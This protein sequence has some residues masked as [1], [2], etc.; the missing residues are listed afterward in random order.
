MPVKPRDPWLDNAKMLL[1]TAVV[2]GHALVLIPPSDLSGRVYDAIYYVHIPAFV[3]ITGY[4]SRSFE[5]TRRH[6]RSL[7]TTL[8]V[9]YLVF[10]GLFALFRQEA[11]GEEPLERLWLDPHWP[12]WYLAVLM[13]WR[14]ATPLLKRHWVAIPIS[15][16]ISVL[17]PLVSIDVLDLNRALA[18]LPF[19]VLGLHFTGW[20]LEQVRRRGAWVVGAVTVLGL[21]W[22]AGGTDTWISTEWLYQRSSYDDLGATV[23]GAFVDRGLLLLIGVVSA[24]GVLTLV[25]HGRSWLTTAGRYSMIVYLLHGFVVKGATYAG[26]DEWLPD[27]PRAQVLITVA[28]GIALACLIAWQPVARVLAPLVDPVNAITRLVRERRAQ[29][30]GASEARSEEAAKTSGVGPQDGSTAER[31][32]SSRV[33]ASWRSGA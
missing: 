14:L 7:V 16:V 11:G 31:G 13:V 15:L 6:F 8:L 2:V 10:E 9:P 18:L 29:S 21:W 30:A 5:W 22:L 27:N 3:L 32:T 28:L 23:P 1:V 25:P 20:E 12:M 17:A 19:F 26:Y 24:F 4:L 33:S